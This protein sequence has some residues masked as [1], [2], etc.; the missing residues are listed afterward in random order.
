MLFL[1][2]LLYETYENLI[3]ERVC[4]GPSV[5]KKADLGILDVEPKFFFFL[6]ILKREK[7]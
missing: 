5:I 2:G 6:Q 4:N 7:Y 1:Q 3:R